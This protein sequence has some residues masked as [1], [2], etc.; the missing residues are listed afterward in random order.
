MAALSRPVLPPGGQRDL[1]NALHALHHR[2]GQPSLRDLARDVGVSRTTVSA[3]FSAP[4]VPRWGIVELLVEA[5][6]GDT[7]AFHTLWMAATPIQHSHPQETAQPQEPPLSR[8]TAAAVPHQLPAPTTHFVG[9][10]AELDRL[11]A[12]GQGNDT[13]PGP[14]IALV[15]GPPGVGK[16]ALAV[17]WAHRHP[18]P[19]G[20]LYIDL[21]GHDAR[22]PVPATV[23]LEGVLRAVGVE[24]RAIPGSQAERAALWRS[25]LA[26]RRILLVLDN[27][28]SLDQVRDLLPG[29]PGSHTVVTSRDSLPGL[30]V[31][32]GA[33]RI[34]LDSLPVADAVELV[35][36]LVGPRA[37]AEPEATEALARLCG[38]LPI[39]LRLAAERAVSR[40]WQSLADLV[41]ELGHESDRLDL[42]DLGDDAGSAVRVVFS[43][44]LA[45]LA[46]R[47]RRA[48]RLMGLP[49]G[50][51]LD[52]DA[53]AALLA[54][55]RGQARLLLDELSR[56]HLVHAGA[57]GY[58]MHDLLRTYAGELLGRE[59]AMDVAPARERLVAYY[60]DRAEKAASVGPAGPGPTTSTP[61]GGAPAASPWL[62]Q[63]RSNLI[64]VAALAAEHH[65][66]QA[67]R[68]SV[69]LSAYLDARGHYADAVAIHEAALGAG[70][71]GHN[72]AAEAAAA[73]RVAL[74][75]RRLGEFTASTQLSRRAL[76]L[77]ERLGDPAGQAEAATSLGIDAWRS[78]RYH[79]SRSH[80]ERALDGYVALGDPAGEGAALYNLGIVH[81]RL[82]DYPGAARHHSR[83]LELQRQIGDRIGE[84]RA[85][86]NAGVVYLRLGQLDRALEMQRE[87]LAILLEHGD[88]AGEAAVLTNVGLVLERQNRLTEALESFDRAAAISRE[89]GYR[90]GEGDALRGRGVVLGRLG[91]VGD[92]VREL[93]EA[94]AIGRAL[95]E[96]DIETGTPHDLAVVLLDAGRLD[97]ALPL[98]RAGLGLAERSDDRYEQA[99]ALVALGRVAEAAGD[100]RQ[101]RRRWT[102]AE[103]IFADLGLPERDWV[104]QRLAGPPPDEAG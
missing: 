74:I 78:G 28:G 47:Q 4:R 54:V 30:V 76:S 2:A 72:Q 82:G 61:L 36:R 92:A 91:R 87:A 68:L 50:G 63:Q 66:D 13:S 58:R 39:A 45:Q 10:T 51:D 52:L 38:C 40:P 29:S 19:D 95:G 41:A 84:G 20:E 49:P 65:P 67:E 93:T 42:L 12:L 15:C 104:A 88:R 7:E 96:A 70:R 73:L 48:F 103:R 1:V 55:D 26:G 69:A 85:L 5:M 71:A 31:R 102:A 83:A 46:P 77:Y 56:L 37:S 35:R 34:Q 101:A 79:E 32:Y 16:S 59:A 33:P 86:V 9:R 8:L 64:A 22:S 100:P 23:A 60:V 18:A 11:D 57:A 27:V 99:R 94:L 80:L 81:R 3:V 89:I 6:G 25:A 44:S 43:W 17:T 14:G 90:V 24:E 97:E 21:R 53:G 98:L 75:R 62:D